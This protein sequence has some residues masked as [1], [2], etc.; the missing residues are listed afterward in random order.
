LMMEMSLTRVVMSSFSSSRV[1]AW[2]SP[3]A[4]AD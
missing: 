4:A 1:T 3:I 2:S